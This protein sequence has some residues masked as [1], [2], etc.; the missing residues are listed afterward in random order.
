MDFCAYTVKF[1]RLGTYVYAAHINHCSIFQVCINQIK[2]KWFFNVQTGL[3]KT[4]KEREGTLVLLWM[5]SPR[6]M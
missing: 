3:E 6:I 4:E 2:K 1:S 5:M